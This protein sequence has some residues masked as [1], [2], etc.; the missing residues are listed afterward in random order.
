MSKR[1][2]CEC[3]GDVIGAYEPMILLED[4]K[5]RKTSVATEQGT[6]RAPGEHYHAACY[7]QQ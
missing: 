7:P 6:N 5:P 2:Y 4:G 3:C 1:P